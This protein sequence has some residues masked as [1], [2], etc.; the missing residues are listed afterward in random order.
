MTTLLFTHP[1]C[2]DH[3]PGPQ[4][5]ER[6]ARLAAIMNALDGPDFAALDRREAPRADDAQ[7]TLVHPALHVQRVLGAVPPH[8]RARIDADTVLSPGSGE[9]A[10]RAAGAVCA[11]VDAV[12]AGEGKNAFCAVR[13]PGHHAEPDRA[14]GFCLFNNVAVG[15]L[16]ARKKHDLRRVAVIDFDVHHGN[17]T[18]AA[19]ERDADLFYASTHQSPL[20]PGTGAM[21][22]RGVAN[23][24]LNL[25]LPPGGDSDLFRLAMEKGVLVALEAFRPEMVFISA[26]FD[27]HAADPLANM[28][29]TTE[30]FGWATARLAGVAQEMC[31]GRLVST[32]EGGYDLDALA[33]SSAAHVRALMAA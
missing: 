14:M 31:R 8:G 26:G 17:G 30:D 9:A 10:L 6:P 12:M 4:H 18:Q 16:H 2:L 7:L 15:A 22:E 29:L 23:N 21:D 11:A 13:P 32:L 27:A 19:F 24:I 1:A 28:E 5:P 33:E 25:P 20:Y 3:D